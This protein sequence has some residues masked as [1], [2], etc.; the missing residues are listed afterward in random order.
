VIVAVVMRVVFLSSALT[1]RVGCSQQPGWPWLPQQDW[2]RRT[3]MSVLDAAI[4]S[5]VANGRGFVAGPVGEHG[6][7]A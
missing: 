2:R 4:R 1:G 5:F 7:R 6:R 3:L